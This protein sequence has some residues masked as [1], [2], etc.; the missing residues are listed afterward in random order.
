MRVLWAVGILLI[1]ATLAA[2]DRNKSSPPESTGQP[3]VPT[4]SFRN[5]TPPRLG[6]KAAAHL[7]YTP[8]ANYSPASTRWSYT[9][10]YGGLTT[11]PVGPIDQRTFDAEISAI[12]PGHYVVTAV[13]SYKRVGQNLNP[14]EPT[15]ANG[16]FDVPVPDGVKPTEG[17]IGKPLGLN[18]AASIEDQITAGGRALGE[19]A[20]GMV[21]ELIPQFTFWNGSTHPGTREAWFPSAPGLGFHFVQPDSTLADLHMFRIAPANWAKIPVG[22]EICTFKQKIRF[23]WTMKGT[24]KGRSAEETFHV[25]LGTLTWTWKKVDPDHWQ[26]ELTESAAP[27][28]LISHDA[29]GPT[30]KDNRVTGTIMGPGP[31][32]PGD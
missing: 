21:Q 1:V 10:T 17:W 5:M 26:T 32:R 19:N 27:D 11:A 31:D 3:V 12:V 6:V 29:V 15:T 24:K 14:P 7:E 13:T 22:Q 20:I 23:S 16:E 4:I 28:Q 9:I 2:Q 8:K 18:V 30:T 25:P